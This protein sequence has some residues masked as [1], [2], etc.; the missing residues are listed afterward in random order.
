M[1]RRAQVTNVSFSM[2]VA[3]I[4]VAISLPSSPS[5]AQQSDSEDRV[6]S[7]KKITV[8]GWATKSK[9]AAAWLLYP[10][11]I[12]MNVV[13]S[14][15]YPYYVKANCSGANLKETVASAVALV[16]KDGIDDKD[17]Y[18]SGRLFGG[19]YKSSGGPKSKEFKLAVDKDALCSSDYKGGMR[20]CVLNENTT[21][22]R[23]FQCLFLS[24]KMLFGI[25]PKAVFWID[26]PSYTFYKTKFGTKAVRKIAE[27]IKPK[28]KA[29]KNS[30]NNSNIEK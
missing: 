18:T 22:G 12:K 8:A 1:E 10:N 19:V 27:L 29:D 13:G 28:S 25:E 23:E 15:A 3:T 7:G 4:I 2:I 17:N 6:D 24:K 21:N 9:I 14:Y 11:Y 16:W 20:N 30:S 5:H 26:R